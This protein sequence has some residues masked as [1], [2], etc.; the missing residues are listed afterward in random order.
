MFAPG[1][2]LGK[3]PDMYKRRSRQTRGSN[4]GTPLGARGLGEARRKAAGVESDEAEAGERS[5]QGAL[6]LAQGCPGWGNRN[7]GTILS[8][9]S[10]AENLPNS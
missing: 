2:S 1:A 8:P 3:D 5:S 7:D 6:I 10:G 9:I 4:T